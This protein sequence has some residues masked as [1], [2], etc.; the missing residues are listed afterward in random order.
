MC[1]ET[2]VGKAKVALVTGASR[3]RGIGTGV[4]RQLARDG[5]DLFVTG[6]SPY[7]CET[8]LAGESNE[9]DAS[10]KSIKRIVF[11]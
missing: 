8:G 10:I 1:T 6:V 4:A 9:T 2:P 5:C 7:D 3:K 11:F